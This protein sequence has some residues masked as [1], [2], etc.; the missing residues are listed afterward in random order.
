MEARG[1]HVRLGGRPVLRDVDLAVG[2]GE[3]VALVG[4]NGAGKS[5]L[6]SVLAGDLTPDAGQ[7]LL[8]GEPLH[9]LP[10][11]RLARR[12]SVLPQS[13]RLAFSFPAE[14]VVRMGR[15]PWWRTPHEQDDDRAVAVALAAADVRHLAVRAYPR[16]SGGERART[17]LAR[18][19]AQDTGVVLL[20]EPTAALDLRHQ[21]S[22][23]ATA[24]R[25]ADAGGVVV[26]VLH[27][28]GLAGA[29]ADRVVVLRDGEVRA[30]GAPSD[31]LVPALVE[32]VYGLPV[33][34]VEVGGRPVVVPV[35]RQSEERA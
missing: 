2:P 4:P 28:L 3:L 11:R 35:R 30:D 25:L 10:A 15:S 33:A 19:L 20:D 18:V 34:V 13:Q 23:L 14:E 1:V 17:D 9:R 26:V 24:R 7:V 21:Q 8:G 29:W 16:L 5:T 31:V 27:D 6:L 32:E 12:R 22:V